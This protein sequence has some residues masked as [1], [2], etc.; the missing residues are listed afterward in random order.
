[1]IGEP[2]Q[3]VFLHQDRH[4]GGIEAGI[5][6]IFRFLVP[7]EI[8]DARDRPAVAIND[9]PLE[10]RINL[11]RRGL[12]DR[13]SERLEKIAVD[14]GDANLEAAEIG[15]RDRLVWI[16]VKWIAIHM[17]RQEKRIHLFGLN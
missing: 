4:F 14:R 8:E 2:V 3:G 17:P 13:R 7:A 9:S 12:N 1:S 6:A 15:L 16:A 10:R 5:D 11:A